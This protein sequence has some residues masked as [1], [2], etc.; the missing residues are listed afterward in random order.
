MERDI[1]AHQLGFF[2]IRA[3]LLWH[4]LRF[5]A[6]TC[7]EKKSKKYITICIFQ[8]LSSK[9][10]TKTVSKEEQFN[11]LVAEN[12]ERIKR[13]C[14]YYNSNTTDQQDMYQ[15]ILVNIW[16]SL[17][18]FRGDS[19]IST[20]IYRIAVNT[21]LSYTGKAYKYMKLMVNAD[22]VNLNSILDDES[23]KAKQ[24]E[25]QQLELL[26][27]E[28]NTLSVIDK[29][30]ISLMLESLSIKEIADV[31]GITEP[32]VKVKIHRIKTQLRKK[33]EGESDGNK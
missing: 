17:H 12:N 7:L 4:E 8:E 18:N 33:L 13:I 20:W 24:I 2:S 11:Q 25:E 29:A 19:A 28:L 10:K 30:L 1:I 26:Q 22:H 14:S 3:I 16:K 23:F 31:I 27:N 15:E 21:S 32:N 9:H 6:L 5:S